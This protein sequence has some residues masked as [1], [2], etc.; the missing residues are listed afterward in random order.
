MNLV[1][2]LLG[3]IGVAEALFAEVIP[4]FSVIPSPQAWGDQGVGVDILLNKRENP[5]NLTSETILTGFYKSQDASPGLA[6]C[7][8]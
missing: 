4:Y 2:L 8:R 5:L 6:S 7:I 1:I 3:K